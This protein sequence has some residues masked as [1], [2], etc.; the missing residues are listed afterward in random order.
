E[1]GTFA[2]EPIIRMFQAGRAAGFRSLPH[3]GEMAGPASIWAALETLGADRIGHGVR[4]LEDPRLVE[5]LR[6]RRIPLEVCPSS[7]VLLGV[8]PS[9]AEHPLPRLM[10]AGLVITL[11]SDDP[12]LFGTDLI[13]E[14]AACAEAFGWSGD[15]LR[16]LVRM[17]LEVSFMP[18]ALRDALET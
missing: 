15:D 7:N 8:A 11:A 1:A 18:D 9:L 13:Q 3:A 6:E 12:T 4:C 14:Y 2:M 16:E 5:V 17:S 10:E